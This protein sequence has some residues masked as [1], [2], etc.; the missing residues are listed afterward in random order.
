MRLSRRRFVQAA[1]AAVAAGCATREALT[2]QALIER[3]QTALGG[4]W[5]TDGVDGFKAGDPA[6]PVKGVATTAMATLEVLKQASAAGAN[7]VLTCEPTFFGKT[8]GPPPP[9][10][11][12]ERRFF[13]PL[14]ADDP[15]YVAKKAFIEE[16][17]LVV[18]RL[19]DNWLANHA[20]D[21]TDGLAEALDWADGRVGSDDALFEIP[22]APAEQVVARIREKLGLRGGLR[23][24]GDR[25]STVRRV[26]L[27][28]GFLDRETMWARYH[29]ADLTLAGEVREWENAFYAA[30]VFTAGGKRNF[31]TIGRVASQDPGMRACAR[32]LES[33]VD[34]P[35]RLL[36][37]GDLYW[38]P[39]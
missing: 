21:M 35:V 34:V 20:A 16:N 6:T 2:A 4:D 15:V 10:K 1:A 27:Y 25:T 28:P 38:R 7:F 19:H 37:A 8:D 5:R 29:D 11:E 22:E 3:L 13:Q 12:G 36:P 18:Y 33:A 17:G 30:D 32:W 23:A 9:P 31:V 24:V 14:A 39:A 26:L